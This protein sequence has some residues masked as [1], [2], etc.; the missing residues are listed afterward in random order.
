MKIVAALIAGRSPVALINISKGGACFLDGSRAHNVVPNVL[1]D[2]VK[3]VLF[4]KPG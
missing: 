2:C 3:T 4:R 1:D